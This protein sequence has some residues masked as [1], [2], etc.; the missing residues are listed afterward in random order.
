MQTGKKK[1][2]RVE[3]E[4]EVA[5][6]YDLDDD[7][8][9]DGDSGG[10]PPD[11]IS[12]L[13]ASQEEEEEGA[14][15]RSWRA[16]AVLTNGKVVGCDL[17]VSATGVRPNGD[18]VRCEGIRLSR[19]D[20]GAVEVNHRMETGVPGVYAAGDVCRVDWGAEHS[21]PLWF[22]MRLWTQARQMGAYAARC[23]AG[24]ADEPDFCFQVRELCS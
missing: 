24:A 2:V 6:V 10:V 16:V 3:F 5:N 9:D 18:L 17:V 11:V 22:Q 23:M 14:G 15:G 4:C 8:D 12:R 7:D 19:E 21:S 13:R 20:E 1:K